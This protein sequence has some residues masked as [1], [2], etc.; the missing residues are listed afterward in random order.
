VDA[1]LR[2]GY[3][4]FSLA[5]IALGIETFV[6]AGSLLGTL[7]QTDRFG[8]ILGPILVVCGVGLLFK[9][10]VRTA[11]MALGSLLFLYTLVFE[12]PKYA[13]A[14]RSMTLRTQVFEPLAIAA[15]AWPGRDTELTGACE[16]LSARGVLH[17]LWSGPFPRAR[18]HRPADTA[19]DSMARV[20]DCIFRCRIHRGR[21]KHRLEFAVALGRGRSRL[22]VCDL[23]LHPSSPQNS[24]WALRWKRPAQSGR[25]VESVHRHCLVGRPVGSGFEYSRSWL[26]ASASA[27]AGRSL[28]YVVGNSKTTS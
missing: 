1:L 14:P 3:M 27:I 23:G 2:S 24:S 7:I 13:G 12:V 17:R 26:A 19:V 5:I 4:M 20:L 15:L 28:L 21:L 25:V 6:W 8:K 10:T 9:R 16:S 18:A 22:D 11:A